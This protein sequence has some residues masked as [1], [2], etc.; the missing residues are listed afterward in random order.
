MNNNLMFSSRYDSWAT[1]IDFFNE[2]NKEFN[3]TIDVCASE[4][5]KK[6]EKYYDITIDGLNQ[7]WTGT[8]FMNPPYGRTIGNWVK[9]AYEESKKG[10]TIVALLPSRTDTKWFHNY[11]INQEVRFIKGRLVFGTDDYWKYL[12]STEY[13]DG[14][15]NPLFG[16]YGKKNSAPF[17]SVVVVFK[18]ENHK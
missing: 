13:I 15:K 16:K 17:P 11:C 4:H 5:N 2:L 10:N 14:K 12:W 8:C 3:F 7:D 9:K 6:C 1:P 18:P